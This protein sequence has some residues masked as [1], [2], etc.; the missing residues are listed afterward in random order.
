[1]GSTDQHNELVSQTLRY[2]NEQFDSSIKY[3]ASGAFAISFAFIKDIVPNLKTAK[4]IELLLLA[5]SAF[6]LT[7]LVSLIC[8]Y[9]STRANTWAHVNQNIEDNDEY[10]QGIESYN[11]PIRWMNVSMIFLILAGAVSLIAFIFNN[12]A[13]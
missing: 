10:N 6:A 8:H 2:S 1:M 4:T 5:W 3:I 12:F 11:K 9:V 7:I 13:I